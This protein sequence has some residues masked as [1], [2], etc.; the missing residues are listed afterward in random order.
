MNPDSK[1][2]SRK[3]ATKDQLELSVLLVYIVQVKG[4]ATLNDIQEYMKDSLN[5]QCNINTLSKVSEQLRKRK[6]FVA[7]NLSGER[8]YSMGK[9][10]FNRG[11][12]VEIAHTNV[13]GL[14]TSLFEDPAGVAIVAEIRGELGTKGP[15]PRDFPTKWGTYIVKMRLIDYMLGGL[16]LDGNPAIAREIAASRYNK[17][18][19]TNC[20][21]K[22]IP[23][24][25][26]RSP[27]GGLRIHT[28][29]VYGFFK[30]HLSSLNVPPSFIQC[31]RF[32]PIDFYPD[33]EKLQVDVWRNPIHRDETQ[34]G[35]GQASSGAGIGHY[36]M[37]PAGTE[38]T[39]RFDAPTKNFPSLQQLTFWLTQS[40]ECSQQ[41]MSPAR[42]KQ[43]GH[44]ELLSLTIEEW[45]DMS[46]KGKKAADDEFVDVDPE[47]ECAGGAA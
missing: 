42:G 29:C 21:P 41:T 10:Q 14:L 1:I 44:A 12:N 23:L 25:F 47:S 31:F 46:F 13:D 26:L 34:T 19:D 36:E 40:L 20:D 35:G 38:I 43:T 6:F 4:E 16:P 28:H 2:K 17:H 11:T 18:I 3:F 7:N 45:P 24:V 30:K 33:P 39:W 27:D 5:S 15:K 22:Q 8:R 32:R 37:V 9:V